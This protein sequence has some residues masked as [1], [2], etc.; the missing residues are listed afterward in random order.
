[1]LRLI[2]LLLTQSENYLLPY[3]VK[4]YTFHSLLIKGTP[5]SN[6]QIIFRA[7][8]DGSATF[9]NKTNLSNTINTDSEDAEIAADLAIEIAEKVLN[10][11]PKD[12]VIE[13]IGLRLDIIQHGWKNMKY[14]FEYK[15]YLRS[16]LKPL[17]VSNEEIHLK[18][19]LTNF[20]LN[21]TVYN[22]NHTN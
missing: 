2:P 1:M 21:T 19:S 16:T 14:L 7:S 8:N 9:G 4:I 5:N 3:Q 11:R 17:T 22:H 13:L 20:C 15:K 10:E 12:S 18:F 6:R